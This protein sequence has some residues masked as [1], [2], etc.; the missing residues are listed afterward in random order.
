MEFFWMVMGFVG[1]C[2]LGGALILFPA[3]ALMGWVARIFEELENEKISKFSAWC[4]GITGTPIM[5]LSS[6]ITYSFVIFIVESTIKY[7]L[8]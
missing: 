3:S 5:V 1:Y 7:P 2:F 6:M 4:Y 8:L